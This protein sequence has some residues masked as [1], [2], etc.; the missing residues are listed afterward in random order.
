M[1]IA[2]VNIVF[3]IGVGIGVREKLQKFIEAISFKR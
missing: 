1:E 2:I 3:Y